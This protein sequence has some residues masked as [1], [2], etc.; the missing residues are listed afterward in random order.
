MTAVEGSNAT[1]LK[2]A[3]TT[4]NERNNVTEVKMAEGALVDTHQPHGSAC[5][6]TRG[7]QKTP[8]LAEHSR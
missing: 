7:E 1:E 5:A 3:T 8:T 2:R 4:E 6:N